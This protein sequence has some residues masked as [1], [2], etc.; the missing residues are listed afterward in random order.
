VQIYVARLKAGCRIVAAGVIMLA[1][2]GCGMF[3]GLFTGPGD[4]K[5]ADPARAVADARRLIAE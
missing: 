3:D 2:T 4:V 1:A 5:I